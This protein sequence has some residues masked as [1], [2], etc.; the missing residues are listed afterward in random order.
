MLMILLGLTIPAICLTLV[1]YFIYKTVAV[2]T[3]NSR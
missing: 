3:K 1:V 2:A